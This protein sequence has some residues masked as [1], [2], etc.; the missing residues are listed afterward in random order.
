MAKRTPAVEKTLAGDLPID[1]STHQ[2]ACRNPQEQGRKTVGLGIVFVK[3]VRHL[4]PQFNHWLSELPDSRF[5]PFVCYNQRFLVWWG[6]LLFCCKLGSRRQL[7]YELRDDETEVLKN[8]NRFAGTDQD[9]LPVHKT[10]DH[11]LGHIGSSALADL[12]TMMVRRLIR[13]KA[14]D[15]FR[16]RGMFVVALDGTGYLSFNSE[17]CPHCLT[18][19]KDKVTTY[20]HPVL[21]AKIVHPAGLALSIGSEF[22]EN[23]A[24]S[25][26]HNTVADYQKEKTKQDCELKAFVRMAPAL[27]KAFPQ[28]PLCICADSLHAC[29]TVMQACRDSGWSFV[30]VFKPG[31]TK[32]LWEDVRGLLTLHPENK[33]T[34]PLPGGTV[35][36]Y[37]WINDVPYVDS[38]G[39]SHCIDA[40]ICEETVKDK[41]TTFAWITDLHVTAGNI[42]EIATKGGRVRSKI[43]NQGFNI[44]KNSGLNLEHAYSTG[45]DN[46]KSF[47]YLLQIAHIILQTIEMGSLL[48]NLASQYKSE[49]VKLFGS[50]K[51]LARRLLD[52]IRYYSIPEEAFNA[53]AAVRMHIRFNSS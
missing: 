23:P 7:D 45:V 27:K 35:Q 1:H 51:N 42:S 47:Y 10:L 41:M 53:T 24:D 46:M 48:Q 30:L 38:R 14:L 2:V 26:N 20:M 4:W 19:T 9:C 16:L 13:M 17:H 21:E 32:T 6:V 31:R 39:R 50:L 44:Q 25:K 15:D 40:I 34:V 52:C 28:T 18:R 36:Q 11:Y 5:Q 43:E 12:R 29:G 37:C 3:T 49:P 33:M 22:I 8:V